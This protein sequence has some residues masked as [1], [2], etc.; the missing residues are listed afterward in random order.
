M[1]DGEV[2]KIIESL[3]RDNEEKIYQMSHVRIVAETMVRGLHEPNYF[4]RV[5]GEFNR[6]FDAQVCALYWFRQRHPAG[7]WLDAWA[8]DANRYRPDKRVLS[9]EKEGILEWV[10]K[11]NKPIFIDAEDCKE[12]VAQW[13]PD[14]PSHI[15]LG[16]LPIKID[17]VRSGMYVLIDPIFKL[18]PKNLQ[19]HIDILSRLLVSGSRNRLLYKRLHESEEEFRDLYENSSDMV[20]VLYRDGVIRD[21]NRVFIEGLLLEKD[22]CGEMMVNFVSED[23]REV[24]GEIWKQLLKGEEVRNVDLSLDKTDKTSIIAELS[25]NV[26][27]LPD[28]SVGII[29]LYLRDLTERIEVERRQ[30]ELEIEL[31]LM[32]ERQLAQVGLYVSGIAHNLQNPV[33][34]LLGYLDVLKM[35]GVNFQELGFIEQSTKNIADIIKNLLSKMREE[36]SREKKLINLNELLE[37][38]LNFLNANLYYKH[39]VKKHYCLDEE[40][41]HVW[42]IYSDFSQAIMNV[43]YNALE[44]M[45]TSDVKELEI[46]TYYADEISSNVISISDTGPGIP[47][48]VQNKIFKPFFTTK[49]GPKHQENTGL[50][51]G[52]GLGLSSSVALLETYKG[53]ITFE[54]EPGQGTTFLITLPTG[55]EEDYEESE[56]L[57]DSR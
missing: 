22:P 6:I 52:S 14:L 34:V 50:D 21:C 54:T 2:Q 17:D 56:G 30:R 16:L 41:P 38:E 42:G 28:G 36:S 19:R 5:C 13:R 55:R 26:R 18:S 7:W 1:T 46:R 25:G 4:S 3:S 31:N 39:E 11:H 23:K 8:S 47:K 24:F 37:N 15:V 10:R 53:N 40:I 43:I 57:S 35:K 51:S 32:Q 33:Q 44:A 48:E 29:R 12:L 45:S 49:G 20:V 27:L 9:V